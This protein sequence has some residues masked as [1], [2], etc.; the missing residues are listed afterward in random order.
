MANIIIGPAK[1][2]QGC[3]TIRQIGE[4]ASKLAKRFLCLISPAGMVRV[5]DAVRESLRQNGCEAE[6]FYFSGECTRAEMQRA[7]KQAE[8]LQ[9]GAIMG[10]GGG[11]IMDSAKGAAFFMNVPVVIVPTVASTDAPCSALVIAYNA[12]GQLDEFLFLPK[13]PDLVLVDCDVVVCA[14]VRMLVA[15]MGDALAT[16]I[17]AEA[18]A[19]AG[20]K[21]CAGGKATLAALAL[22]RQCYDTLMEDGLAAKLA[23]ERHVCTAAVEHVIEANTYLSGIGFESGGLCAAH[24]INNGFALLEECHHLYHGEKVAFGTIVQMIL[25]NAPVEALKE[26]VGF[27]RTVGLPVTLE[28]MG[29]GAGDRE[30]LMT[31][32]NAAAGKQEAIHNLPMEITP[33]KVYAAIIGADAFG[34]YMKAI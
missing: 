32:A 15:G 22:A 25:Q 26:V 5:G 21:T 20:G 13:N 6:F 9:C 17:E 12:E 11:K 28:E 19:R 3:G 34:Q 33:E 10:I 29:L 2:V 24:T 8:K 16:Y 18:S 30:R 1:Y 31:V 23:A 4:Y 27:C 7:A 14:P